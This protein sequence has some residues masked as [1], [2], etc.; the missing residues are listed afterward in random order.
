MQNLVGG[1]SRP[2]SAYSSISS[3]ELGAGGEIGPCVGSDGRESPSVPPAAGALVM[4]MRLRAA[5]HHIFQASS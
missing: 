4:T 1:T 3:D 5:M 2:L